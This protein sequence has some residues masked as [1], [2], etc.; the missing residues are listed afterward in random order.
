[1]ENNQKV[2]GEL[3]GVS[4]E[5]SLLFLTQGAMVFVTFQLPMIEY[6]AFNVENPMKMSLR[7]FN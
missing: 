2:R 4:V 7:S 6:M 5:H 3:K 1:M